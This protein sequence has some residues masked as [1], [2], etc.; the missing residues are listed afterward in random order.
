M[1]FHLG[2][3]LAKQADKPKAISMLERALE[4]DRGHA[5]ASEL[6]AQLKS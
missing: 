5:R 2:E 4:A 1:Y 3:T 6:L